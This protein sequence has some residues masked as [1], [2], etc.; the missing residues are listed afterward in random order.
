[1]KFTDEQTELIAKMHREHAETNGRYLRKGKEAYAIWAYVLAI[2]VASLL[3]TSGLITESKIDN[4]FKTFSKEVEVH[5][6]H[7]ITRQASFIAFDD[8]GNKT[9]E[10]TVSEITKEH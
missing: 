10:G 9:H 4:F 3:S 6:N 2:D 8:Y 1:M 5:V 7:L